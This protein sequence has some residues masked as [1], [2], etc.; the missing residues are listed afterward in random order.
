MQY[1]YARHPDLACARLGLE[2][3][4]A[5]FAAMNMPPAGIWRIAKAGG[6]RLSRDR[7][8]DGSSEGQRGHVRKGCFWRDDSLDGGSRAQMSGIV[9]RVAV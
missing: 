4:K 5:R 7:H 9:C 6:A 8:I 1:T 3:R 2:C